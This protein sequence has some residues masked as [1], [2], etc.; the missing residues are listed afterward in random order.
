VNHDEIHQFWAI[1]LHNRYI[2]YRNWL[3]YVL[4][5]QD[6]FQ[7]KKIKY[8]F[9]TALDTNYINDFLVDSDQSLLLSDLSWQWRDRSKYKPCRD[10]HHEHQELRTLVSKIDL[11]QWVG[12]PQQTMQSY[13]ATHN[14]PTDKTKHFLADGHSAWADYIKATL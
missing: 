7:T 3:T 2:N 10:I 4:H 11:T 12:D 14:F 8:R 5:L 13:L 6:Y 1:K 9:F